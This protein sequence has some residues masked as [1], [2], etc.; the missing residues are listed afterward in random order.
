M[1]YTKYIFCAIMRHYAILYISSLIIYVLKGY[2]YYSIIQIVE[3]MP[4]L[5]KAS[6]GF[7]WDA[8]PGDFFAP[9]IPPV[10]WLYAYKVYTAP[11]GICRPS[12][13]CFCVWRLRR[14]LGAS[15]GLVDCAF[16]YPRQFGNF[17]LGVYGIC[18]SQIWVKQNTPLTAL[19][20]LF[21]L[22]RNQRLKL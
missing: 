7:N 18:F 11:S 17:G 6:P 5:Q 13:K 20:I 4:R 19:L 12:G 9:A 2:T 8:D 15:R 3:K 16:A 1:N 10:P 14:V 21:C 22:C